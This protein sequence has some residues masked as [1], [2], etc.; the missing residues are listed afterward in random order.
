MKKIGILASHNGSGFLSLYDAIQRNEIEATIELVITNNSGANV[1]KS[2]QELGI[3]AE[4]VN[5]KLY[6]NESVDK[7]IIS[8]LKKSGCE[9]VLLSGYMKMLGEELVNS[10][11]IINTHP[12]LLPKFGGK[13][14]YGRFVHEAVINSKETKS[15]VT[16]HYVN[17]EYDKGEI[18][19]QKEL[20]LD[21]DESV[22]S[23]EEKIKSLEKKAIIEAFK[24]VINS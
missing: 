1:I 9:I 21:N 15:G 19:L 17:G 2:A 24:K 18:I 13:G 10:F 4:V 23:L 14:M 20:L 5:T 12:S 3:R 7:V 11:N 6:P 16:V 8:E 22:N